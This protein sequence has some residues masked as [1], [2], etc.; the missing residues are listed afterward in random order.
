MH[1]RILVMVI[2]TASISPFSGCGK[3][4]VPGSCKYNVDCDDGN[5]CTQDRC[6][7]N[8]CQNTE[9]PEGTACDDGMYC[10]GIDTCDDSGQCSVHSGNP[11][12]VHVCDDASEACTCTTEGSCFVQVTAGMIHTCG[13]TV[14]GI[15]YC[16]GSNHHGQLGDGA[17]GPSLSSH[18]PVM[19]DT[20]VITGKRAFVQLSACHWHTCGITADG[21][22]YCWGRGDDGE[23]G[24]GGSSL[25]NPLP[26]PV[27]TSGVTGAKTFK[28]IAGG[29]FHTCGLTTSGYVY[30]WGSDYYGQ[31]GN[32]GYQEDSLV[33]IPVRAGG[34]DDG[35]SISQLMSGSE[36][37]CVLT[38]LGE[39]YCWGDNRA[40]Q[41]GD[42][43][44]S[45]NS[46]YPVL[47]DTAGIT[48]E[49][50]FIQIQTGGGSARTCGLTVDSIA[51]CWGGDSFGALGNGGDS[52]S[53]RVPVRVET[54]G[55][56]GGVFNKFTA[57]VYH[58]CGLT[59]EGLAYC[60]GSDEFGQLGDGGS[61]QDSQ[62]PVQ[63]DMSEVVGKRAF[64]QISAGGQHTCG[65]TKEGR[66][67]CWGS[68]NTGQLGSGEGWEDSQVPVPVVVDN[69]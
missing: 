65:V 5:N 32:G 31:L 63:V 33:P 59:H 52:Q 55:V 25:D 40:G 23:L 61:S 60:W 14:E 19:V 43:E 20:S 44:I 35:K 34:I 58:T 62:V 67:Y 22:G 68:D 30:C 6:V 12:G 10:N 11:C 21:L 57:D 2:F 54:S 41:L 13:L 24:S 56:A 39:V 69:L 42:G 9:N 37:S 18:V 26:I 7:E 53:S 1:F 8:K 64:A 36:H 29:M 16:W 15:A 47:V 66:V 49:K 17:G 38:A 4:G 45:Q 48:G 51:Y 50:A 27:D 46:H 3:S 28:Q